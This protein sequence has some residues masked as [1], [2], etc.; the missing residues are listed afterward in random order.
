MLR[1]NNLNVPLSY[2]DDTLREIVLR[3]L[4]IP[5]A[6]LKSVTLVKRSVDARDKGDVHF[7][8]TLDAMVD[9]EDEL[10][11]QLKSN[12]AVRV[13]KKKPLPLPKAAF[14]RRPVV[15]GAGP[16]G[17]FAAL[18]LARAGAA[19]ILIERGKPVDQRTQDV[20][21]MR[22]RGQLDPDSNVQFGEGGAGAFSDGK[23][24]TGI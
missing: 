12:I 17:L 24:N 6:R 1:L 20:D 5:A 15:V 2:S 4:R 21:L 7:V 9:R 11:R 3:K 22:Q 16:A 18:M 13:E 23:L 14:T 10:L 8:M 19:P